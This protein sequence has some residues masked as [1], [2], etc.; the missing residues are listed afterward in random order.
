NRAGA[1]ISTFVYLDE[2]EEVQFDSEIDR[3]AK[4]YVLTS[5]DE[6]GSVPDIFSIVFRDSVYQIYT[7]EMRAPTTIGYLLLGFKVG[8]NVANPI[9]KLTGLNIAIVQTGKNTLTAVSAFDDAHGHVSPSELLDSNQAGGAVYPVRV[10]SEEFWVTH[11]PL[12]HKD[13]RVFIVLA[14][15][16]LK[17]L[18]HF[19]NAKDSVL[20]FDLGLLVLV[21]ALGAWLSANFS[22]PIRRLAVA[23]C[24][25]AK[26]D[27][28]AEI[29]V[30]STDEIGELAMG[31][32]EMRK[33]VASRESQI[34]HQLM[35]DQ[36]TGLPNQKYVIGVLE[37]Y[38]SDVSVSCVALIA[39]KIQNV[40]HISS[41]LGLHAT[42]ELIGEIANSIVSVAGDAN[43]VCCL[44]NYQ[45]AVLCANADDHVARKMAMCITD[46]LDLG[47]TLGA[48]KITLKSYTGIAHYPSHTRSAENLIRYAMIASVDAK[49]DKKRTNTYDTG[50]EADFTRYLKIVQ[51]LP[52]AV[53]RDELQ[54]YFQPKV[55]IDTGELYGAEALV[56][57]QHREL[58][59][60]PPDDFITAAERS[61]NI[62]LLTRFVLRR[63]INAAR[64]WQDAGY[65]LK[66]AVNLS[67]RD[68]L[69]K[70]LLSF[71]AA[72]LDEHQLPPTRLIL[73]ITESSVME[74]L[75]LAVATL[76][77]F[78]ETGILISID[79]FGTGH[80]S[81]AHLRDLPLDELKID[82]SFV[83]QISS[84]TTSELLVS[85]TIALAH[86]MGL[87]V[88]AE[89]IEDEY[90]L[91][92]LAYYDCEIAQGYF[93]SRPLPETDFMQWMCNFES[94]DYAERRGLRRPFM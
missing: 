25:L 28:D 65:S 49:R 29:T 80:S 88:V 61:D 24:S 51:D 44:G 10:G 82:K 87:K 59:F 39:V 53:E 68:L 62:K 22:R 56:R 41:S 69:D 54:V 7:A 5:L 11:L 78:R 4:K 42:E 8:E 12:T 47:T 70:G 30:S 83:S 93:F 85:T 13:E 91:R 18:E 79:D 32:E 57:W 3:K 74:E 33:A 76:K 17:P 43:F 2:D 58:G 60:L 55:L 75:D 64:C 45:F 36:L 20:V 72:T 92:R 52:D 1:D 34:S 73:E 26:G 84:D 35:H 15:K 40:D 50:R 46:K 89:G 71:V 90:C 23:T 81:L 21:V 37:K 94:S 63:A 9:R 19:L 6:E 86:G 27:Y 38:F 77:S 48:S 31:F 66:V 67:A 16:K 14:S